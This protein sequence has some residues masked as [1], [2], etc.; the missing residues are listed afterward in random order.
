MSLRLRLPVSWCVI[1]AG[2]VALV[3][4]VPPAHAAQEGSR[5]IGDSYFP[6][7]GNGG[8]DALRYG[9]RVRYDPATMRLRG[10]TRVRVRAL[11]DLSSLNLDLLLPV[12]GVRVSGRPA[13][14]HKPTRHELTVRLRPV[15]R[16]G[17]TATIKVTYGGYPG[18]YSYAGE[19]NWLADSTEMVAMNQPHMAPWWFPANDHPRDRAR[20]KVRANVPSGMEAVSNGLLRRH[21]TGPH[22]D[23]WTWRADEAMAPYLAFLAVGDFSLRRGNVA[24]RSWVTAVSRRLVPTAGNAAHAWLAR[25]REVISW[26]SDQVGPYPFTASGGLVT[27][28]NVG[29]ALEN[30]TRPTYGRWAIGNN[31]VLAHEVAHQWFGDAITV[32]RWRDIWLNE[33]F[34]TYY[35]VLWQE[36]SGGPTVG[37]WLRAAYDSRSDSFWRLPIGDPGPDRLFDGAVYI[38]GGMTLAALREQIGD[39]SFRALVRRWYAEQRGGSATTEDFITLAESVSGQQLDTFFHR[40]IYAT[41]R[42][43]RP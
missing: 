18:R 6:A 11:R 22:R 38:R 8:Y 5:G 7:D 28:L 33:G 16:R 29:F 14:F 9:I 1:L 21:R 19:R 3:G 10:V 13:A 23:I 25:E 31:A 12:Q 36:H 43:P 17:E 26:L 40:W 34:A 37:E 30:Q 35:E 20:V 27:A 2:V 39:A 24:G 15:L 32:H 4:V 42:P 41:S